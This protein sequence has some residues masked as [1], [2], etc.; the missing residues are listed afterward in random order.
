LV[1]WQHLSEA[2]QHIH[3]DDYQFE[4][5]NKLKRELV[6]IVVDVLPGLGQVLPRY[7]ERLPRSP[8]H[9]VPRNGFCIRFG[10]ARFCKA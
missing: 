1:A 5:Y 3:H 7:Q 10:W 6:V 4:Q 2:W 8:C 9:V